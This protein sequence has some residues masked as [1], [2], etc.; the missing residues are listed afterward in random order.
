[1]GEIKDSPNRKAKLIGSF[2]GIGIGLYIL[3]P[4]VMDIVEPTDPPRCENVQAIDVIHR[5]KATML[6]L[7]STDPSKP[8]R[9]WHAGAYTKPFSPD[10]RGPAVLV[11]QKGH[12][13][14]ADHVHLYPA[15]PLTSIDP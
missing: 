14:G 12:W 1:M 10:Y 8:I 4:I 13:S 7:E 11:V 3:Y 2:I 6:V 15:C 9:R 5:T